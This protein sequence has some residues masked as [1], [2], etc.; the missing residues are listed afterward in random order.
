MMPFLCTQAW[1]LLCYEGLGISIWPMIVPP[2]ISIS[3]WDA[4]AP[5]ASHLFLL[6][7]AAILIPLILG[8]TS[9][10]YWT[11]RGKVRPGENYK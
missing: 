1:F 9:S 3:N 8:Y 5:S 10:S 7:G 11:F 4:A 6:V 2:S